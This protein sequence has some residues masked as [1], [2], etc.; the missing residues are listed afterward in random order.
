MDR[1]VVR[2][3]DPGMHKL[4]VFILGTVLAVPA[5]A[6]AGKTVTAGDQTL[7]ITAKVTPA[8]AGTK[9]KPRGARLQLHVDYESLN[10]GAQIKESTKSI[11]LTMPKGM[12]LHPSTAETCTLSALLRDGDTACPAGS[13]VGQGKGTADPRP[14]LP[15]PIDATIALYNGIDDVAPD[16]SPRDKGI[17]AVIMYAKTSIGVNATL[18]FDIKGNKLLLEYA[19]PAE[20]SSQLFHIQK[21]DISIPNGKKPYVTVPTTCKKPWSFSMAVANFD[22]PTVTASHSVKCKRA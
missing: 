5:S 16:G 12:A 14:T 15:E 11:L 19:P 6:L 7:Q 8:K 21:V 3:E 22:G 4:P 17:P 2:G 9:K 1:G 10:E 18:P 13:L 20:G